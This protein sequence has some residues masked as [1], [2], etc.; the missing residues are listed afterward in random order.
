MI[1]DDIRARKYA[2]QMGLKITGTLGVL[3][4]AKQ[5]GVIASV[6]P[7]L[8]RIKKTDF[9]LTEELELRVLEKSNE[10]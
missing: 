10:K 9:R 6:K 7:I 3:I 2:Q 1:V 8:E 4:L 5:K